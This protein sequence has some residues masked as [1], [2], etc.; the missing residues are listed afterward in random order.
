MELHKTTKLAPI[1][2]MATK[3]LSFTPE[4]VG[5]CEGPLQ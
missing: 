1:P 2:I 5:P 3:L 4:K